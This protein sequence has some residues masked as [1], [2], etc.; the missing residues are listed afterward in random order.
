M[1]KKA[2]IYDIAKKLN[3]TAATVSRALNDNKF[4]SAKTKELV[5]ATAMELN[6][7]KNASAFALKSG[8]T[9]LIGL[10]VPYINRHFFSNII[11]GVEE[12]LNPKDYH[13]MIF[14]SNDSYKKEKEI[15]NRMLKI[16]VDGIMISIAKSTLDSKHL[17]KIINQKIPLVFFD[18]KLQLKNTNSVVLDDVEGG[19]L[20][21]HHLIQQG[22]SKIACVISN[23]SLDIY[24][25]RLSGFI[26]AHKENGMNHNPDLIYEADSSLESG[27]EVADK[28]I[29]IINDVDA[30]FCSSDYTALG[31]S[32]RLQ[33]E[34]I[35]IPK[36]IK[37]V[38]FSNEPFTSLLELPLST[39]EQS[40]YEMGKTSARILL[41]QLNNE[42]ISIEH[43]VKIQPELVERL[44]SQNT[45]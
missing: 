17:E 12:E 35:N 20:A 22:C 29:T 33:E 40:P 25:N 34:G 39:V 11:M 26:K 13:V 7:E 6:Y 18:R 14:Q 4:I 45:K 32:Q 36:K 31:V 42:V 27:H 2:T 8:K 44:S 28:I 10:V 21:T 9:K 5:L 15:I 41:D 3:I 37:I 38:G 23:P 43:S 30:V 1:K 24:R 19:R 16:Q